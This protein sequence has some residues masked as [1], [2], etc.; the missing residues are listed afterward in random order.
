VFSKTLSESGSYLKANLPVAVSGKISIRDEK[1]PQLMVD[2]VAPLGKIDE[3][4][5]EAKSV[6]ERVLWIR[7]PNGGER[8][9]WLR[10][11]MD[12]FPGKETAIVYLEDSKKRLQ[13]QCVIHDALLAEL[14][15]VLGSAN[16]VLKE[17]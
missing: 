8:F 2:R 17:K 7:L 5:P 10:K 14:N 1:E 13:T 6:R 15:E 11:L 9:T 16:V 4:K 3:P 12:M